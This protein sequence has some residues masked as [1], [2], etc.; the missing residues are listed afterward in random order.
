MRL[1]H[2]PGL[3]INTYFIKKKPTEKGY[4]FDGLSTLQARSVMGGIKIG[5]Q[6]TGINLTGTGDGFPIPRFCIEPK[7]GICLLMIIAYLLY[8]LDRITRD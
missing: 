8:S 7:N 1:L 3:C 2:R 5:P 6:T 4:K